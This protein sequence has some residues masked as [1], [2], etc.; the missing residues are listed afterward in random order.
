MALDLGISLKVETSSLN[1]AIK[2]VEKFKKTIEG[3]NTAKIPKKSFDDASTSVSNLGKSVQKTGKQSISIL[4]KQRL[5]AKFLAGDFTKGEAS[6]LAT[7]KAAGLTNIQ[8]KEL[9]NT[10]KQI[11]KLSGK[12]PFDDSVNPLRRLTAESEKLVNKMKVLRGETLLTAKQLEEL[13]ILQ[14]RAEASARSRGISGAALQSTINK[15][16]RDYIKEAE[17][18]N[19][20]QSAY[21]IELEKTKQKRVEEDRIQRLNATGIAASVKQQERLNKLVS[22][23]ALKSDLIRQGLSPTTANMVVRAV[24]SGASAEGPEVK[25]LIESR[26]AIENVN[27]AKKK[28]KE[29]SSATYKAIV[30]GNKNAKIHIDGLQ[31]AVRAI[32]PGFGALS[33]VA[34]SA[35]VVAGA[36]RMADAY[37]SLQE[38]I[39]LLSKTEEGRLEIQNEIIRLSR[40]NRTNL[41]ETGNLYIRLQNAIEQLGGTQQATSIVTEAFGKTLGISKVSGQEAASSILQFSQALASGRLQGDE[42]RAIAEANPRLLRAIGDGANK[43]TAELRKMSS[44]GLLTTAFV[45]KAL[46]SQ[47][48]VLRY[49]FEQVKPSISQAFETLRTNTIVALGELDNVTGFTEGFAMSIQGLGESISRV[50]PSLI[51]SV[52]SI[53]DSFSSASASVGGFIKDNIQDFQ[54]LTISI[55]GVAGVMATKYVASTALATTATGALSAATAVYIAAGGGLSGIMSVI[56]ATS[57]AATAAIVRKTGAMAAITAATLTYNVAGGGLAGVFA[58]ITAGVAAATRGIIAM[59]AALLT[60]PFVLVAAGISAIA[61]AIGGDTILSYLDKLANKL[62]GVRN[63]AQDFSKGLETEILR[64]Q[65]RVKIL[66]DKQTK[67][68]EKRKLLDQASRSDAISDMVKSKT[69]QLDK[70]KGLSDLEIKNEKEKIKKLEDILRDEQKLNI[71][72]VSGIKDKTEENIKTFA[73]SNISQEYEARIQTEKKRFDYERDLIDKK[74]QYELMSAG[75]AEIEKQKLAE[76]TYKKEKALLEEQKAMISRTAITATSEKEKQSQKDSIVAQKKVIGEKIKALDIDRQR[77]IA[78]AEIIKFGEAEKANAIQLR[79]IEKIRADVQEDLLRKQIEFNNQFKD[80]AILAGEQA[81]LQIADKY[82]SKISEAQSE[83]NRLN[84]LGYSKTNIELER[85]Q[86]YLDALK[87]SQKELSEQA[88]KEAETRARYNQTLEAGF[89][90]AIRNRQSDFNDLSR[91][92]EGF[93][94]GF[95]NVFDTSLENS[96]KNFKFKFG[97]VFKYIRDELKKILI[98]QLILKPIKMIVDPVITEMGKAMLSVIYQAAAKAFA[99]DTISSGIDVVSLGKSLIGDISDV[100]DS[101]L[102]GLSKISELFSKGFVGLEN[103]IYNG[104][105]GALNTVGITGGTNIALSTAGT[106]AAGLATGYGV[107]RLLAGGYQVGGT[108]GNISKNS[109]LI[110]ALFGPMG[111][112]IGGAIGGAINGLFG[113]KV[114]QTTGIQGS[115]TSDGFTGKGF[116]E[117]TTKRRFRSTKV[118]TQYSALNKDYENSLDSAIKSTFDGAKSLLKVL[119][120]GSEAAIDSYVQSGRFFI[121]NTSELN[122]FLNT[123]SNSL[124][125]RAIPSLKQFQKQGESL[126]QTG[127]RVANSLLGLNNLT[128]ILGNITKFDFS[129]F[130]QGEKLVESLQSDDFKNAIDFYVENFADKADVFKAKSDSFNFQ[131]TQLGMSLSELSSVSTKED[132]TRLIK[133]IDLT[134]ESSQK[135]LN[136]LLSLAPSLKEIIDLREQESESLERLKGFGK[137][138]REFIDSVIFQNSSPTQN[139]ASTQAEFQKVLALTASSSVDVRDEALR[140]IPEIAR[141]YID[142]AKQYFGSSS[143]YQD[144]Q[145]QV[146]GA[147]E[148]LP[149]VISFDRQQAS[150]TPFANGG[151]FTNSV[152]SAPTLAPMA[153]FGESGSEAIMPLTRGP[154]GSLGVVSYGNSVDTSPLI[155]ELCARVDNLTRVVQTYAKADLETS[156]EILIEQRSTAKNI[157]QAVESRD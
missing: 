42:F 54:A 120:T 67:E 64:A 61:Y 117:T 106:A 145:S 83:V 118:D 20:L 59:G 101:P 27:E 70:L 35:T 47:L 12:N 144:I 58:V 40:E 150:I 96:V 51:S 32:I 3:I 90:R 112:I 49:E 85:A 95:Y 39:K 25:S 98:Q 53:K 69:E 86:G 104:F 82:T 79:D 5:I 46:A 88:Q 71:A 43:T 6:I 127:L 11:F 131:V 138:I 74:F 80:P 37:R 129:N 133:G 136:S 151:V 102:S 38:R 157:R 28:L 119:G 93:M 10:L 155:R 99:K 116:V 149:A 18:V 124:L 72:S 81:R 29:T 16:T 60:N 13:T 84:K 31:A 21:N 154:G 56:T 156:S 8:M 63:A 123:L 45:S 89:Q 148:N 108:V 94:N 128:K 7:G 65:Q 22:D 44:E 91:V 147:L 153:L 97:N 36:I 126:A 23:T 109:A 125:S 1:A 132:F 78:I 121:R 17:R 4:E 141:A 73:L 107:N 48:S 75:I 110:G 24:S 2:E 92:S 26:K 57:T 34:V 41:V 146:L 14:A 142:V 9:E 143:A 134:T 105:A 113:K 139:I 140:S 135:L 122:S 152:A 55:I 130:K 66:S 87:A 62:M 15:S 100:F 111:S 77:T 30:D 76:N 33:A 137:T 114:S 103:S 115:V 50:T 52:K 19:A 68:E